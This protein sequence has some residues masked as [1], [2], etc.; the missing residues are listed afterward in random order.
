MRSMT[1]TFKM[2]LRNFFDDDWK[3]KENLCITNIQIVTSNIQIIS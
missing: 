3:S 2:V 1:G